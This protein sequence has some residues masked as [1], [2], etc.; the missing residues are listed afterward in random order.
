MGDCF[1][2]R[3]HQFVL[4]PLEGVVNSQIDFPGRVYSFEE[5]QSM[6]LDVTFAASADALPA[7]KGIHS[8]CR[9]FYH[10]RR[11]DNL[12]PVFEVPGVRVFVN[13]TSMYREDA[14]RYGIAPFKALGG[15]NFG[16]FTPKNLETH[17]TTVTILSEYRANAGNMGTKIVIHSCEDL[18]RKGYGVRLI[19]VSSLAD[20]GIRNRIKKFTCGVPHKFV[21][22]CSVH[23]WNS[24]FHEADIFVSASRNLSWASMCAKAMAAGLPLVSAN[25][26]T[27]DFLE[28]RVTGLKAKR[29]RYSLSRAIKELIESPKIRNQLASAG[30][31]RIRDYDWNVLVDRILR[32]LNE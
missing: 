26:G 17:Q 6:K 20:E 15:V 4:C 10:L 27:V 24:L 3:G 32:H 23:D 9:I 28:H 25:P 21:R 2:S 1:T 14:G 12:R 31:R 16:M 30:N 5:L 18:Y 8:N 11:E 13:S 22:E 19:L 7:L 29:N